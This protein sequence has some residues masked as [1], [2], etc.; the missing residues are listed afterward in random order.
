MTDENLTGPQLF[1]TGQYY[2]KAARNAANNAP[3][4]ADYDQNDRDRLAGDAADNHA[5]ISSMAAIATAAFAGAHAAAFGQL[6]ADAAY[7][8]GDT[9]LSMAWATAVGARPK[10]GE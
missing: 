5:Y 8:E 1:D 2:L 7:D 3:E 4:A 6:A 9:G 10:D